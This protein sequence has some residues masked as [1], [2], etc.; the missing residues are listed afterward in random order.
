MIVCSCNVLSDRDIRQAVNTAAD[1]LLNAKQIYD[2]LGC[3]AECGRCA[4]SIKVIIEEACNECA[5][6]CRA[7]Y[8]HRQT[9]DDARDEARV[10]LAAPNLLG[11]AG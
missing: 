7:D 2:C 6:A 11:S 9:M 10:A 4:R 8:P 5:S 1:E 3:T